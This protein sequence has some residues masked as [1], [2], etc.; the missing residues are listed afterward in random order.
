MFMNQVLQ[1][2]A[3]EFGFVFTLT[4]LIP[5]YFII[6]SMFRQLMPF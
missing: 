5:V 4:T 1:H 3:F 6:W 2:R